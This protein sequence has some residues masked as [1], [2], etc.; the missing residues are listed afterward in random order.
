[1]GSPLLSQATGPLRKVGTWIPQ[2]SRQPAG[3]LVAD[4][5][6]PH[7]TISTNPGKFSHS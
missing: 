1:M 5:G 2:S 6:Q 3:G 4:W 7:P